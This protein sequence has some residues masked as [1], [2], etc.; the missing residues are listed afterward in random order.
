[1]GQTGRRPG[2]TSNCLFLATTDEG[3][4]RAAA[5][6]DLWQQGFV[7]PVVAPPKPFHILAQRLMA[8]VLQERG[9]GRSEWFDRVSAVS[10]YAEMDRQAVSDL[11]AFMLRSSI[12]WSDNGILS[13]APD[14]EAKYGRK[15]FMELLS[16]FTSPPLFRV[17][18]G[19]K[20]PRVHLLQTGRR[21]ISDRPC[22]SELEDEPSRLEAADRLRRIHRRAWAL[23]LAW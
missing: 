7:E 8:L 13:F 5:L 16:V 2:T 23:S 12:L 10:G 6:L 17:V 19:Q 11:M 3:L 14:G 9:V 22:R 1:M 4:L 20:R 18:A 15:N 21:A